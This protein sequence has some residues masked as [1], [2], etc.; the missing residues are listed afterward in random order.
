[1]STKKNK[2]KEAKDNQNIDPA[3]NIFSINLTTTDDYYRLLLHATDYY[4]DD[5]HHHHQNH[6]K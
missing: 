2:M 4:H 6:Q 3:M 1:M 5:D